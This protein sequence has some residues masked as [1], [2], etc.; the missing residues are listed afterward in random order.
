MRVRVRAR[1]L[2]TLPE[3]EG[4]GHRL[5]AWLEERLH[6]SKPVPPVGIVLRPEVVEV[7]DLMTAHRAHGT[8]PHRLLAA[9]AHSVGPAGPAQAVGLFGRFT[10]QRRARGTVRRAPCALVFLEWEDNRWWQWHGLLDEQDALVEGSKMVREAALGDALP[11]GVGNW[12][13]TARRLGLS[14][15]PGLPIHEPTP[16]IVH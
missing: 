15:H 16:G 7:V 14:A 10:L 8:S 5:A 6:A 11:R 3:A 13:S 2:D 9:L 12:W 1:P 4:V